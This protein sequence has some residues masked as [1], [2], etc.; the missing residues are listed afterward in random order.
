MTE[1]AEAQGLDI[2]RV[3]QETFAVVGRQF[4]TFILLAIILVGAPTA[5]VQVLTGAMAGNLVTASRFS[6]SGPQVGLGLLAFFVTVAT[7]TILQA[8]VIYGAASDLN[9]RPFSLTDS[10]RVGLRAF[11][12][13]IGLGI[14]LAIAVGVGFVLFI[15]PGVLMALAWCVAV[16]AY[17]VEQTGVFGAFERS[18]ALTRGNRLRILA[19][20][21]LWFVGF[22]ALSLIFGIVS[23]VLA[24]ASLGLFK[25]V[26]EVVL[27]PLLSVFIA[28]IGSTLSATLYVELRRV[29][30]GA[31]PQALAALFD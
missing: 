20:G 9:G 13:L 27:Q 10:L 22:I 26:Q 3:V 12:P 2:G 18:A 1:M 24:F 19:L 28:L 5:V 25:I 31:G 30:E 7:T 29:R 16:P 6:M 4:S 8:T 11:L 23:G 21:L 15:V 17:V 14:M